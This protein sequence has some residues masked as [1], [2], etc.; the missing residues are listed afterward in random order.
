MMTHCCVT[1]TNTAT[2]YT[3]ID[4][5]FFLI[6]YLKK[7]EIKRLGII[8]KRKYLKYI[9]FQKCCFEI[10]SNYAQNS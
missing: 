2:P 1:R 6:F 10:T 3:I 4:M 7:Y 8:Q 9:F 5:G